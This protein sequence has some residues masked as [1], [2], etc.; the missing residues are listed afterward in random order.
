MRARPIQSAQNVGDARRQFPPVKRLGDVVVGAGLEAAQS[1][2]IVAEC[3]KHDDAD[4]EPPPQFGNGVEPIAGR[5]GA[6]EQDEIDGFLAQNPF[7][8]VRVLGGEDAAILVLQK[9]HEHG[10]DIV[11]V[12]ND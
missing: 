6:V 3:G 12:V 7:H 5:H 4:I 11:V 9:L 8:G 2:G 1:I 10:A